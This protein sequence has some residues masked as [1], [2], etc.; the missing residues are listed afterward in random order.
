MSLNAIFD[1]YSILFIFKKLL[2]LQY[3]SRG[4]TFYFSRN[5]VEILLITSKVTKSLGRYL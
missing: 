1:Y 4:Q 5:I 3:Y 2:L